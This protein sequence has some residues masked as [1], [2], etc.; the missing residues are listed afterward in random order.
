MAD[1]GNH[2]EAKH[3]VLLGPMYPYRGGI[4]HFLGE[5]ERG[6]QARGH[7]TTGIT[8]SRQFPASLFPGKTQYESEE[9][10]ASTKALRL[11]DTLRPGS[12][13]RTASY[14]EG[15]EPD[16]VIFQ[17]WMPFFGPAFGTV[18]RRL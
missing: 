6:L 13:F 14:I 15:L 12:W 7:R 4:A 8:F 1:G 5:M 9:A 16:A 11:L 18:A 3:F 2:T 10:P 17:Y